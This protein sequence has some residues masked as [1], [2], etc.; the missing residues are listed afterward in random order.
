MSVSILPK[1]LILDVVVAC[2]LR[3]AHMECFAEVNI[4]HV[5]LSHVY[6]A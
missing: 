2:S 1:D 3:Y 6:G 4:V 5:I